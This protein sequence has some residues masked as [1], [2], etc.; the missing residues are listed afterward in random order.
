[1][2]KKKM[3]RREFL[4]LTALTGAGLAITACQPTSAP[5][6]AA[7][8]QVPPTA[9]PPAAAPTAIPAAAGPKL[10]GTFKIAQLGDFNSW[11]AWTMS[12][13]ND[14]MHNLAYSRLIW[15]DGNGEIHPDLAESWDMASDGLTLTMKLR[16]DVTWHDG[17]PFKAG[18]MVEMFG[19]T[20]DEA[21]KDVSG[22]QKIT[23]LLK[24][25]QGVTAPDDSTLVLTFPQPVPF[26][27]DILDYWY[28]ILI[29]DKTDG[30]LT[31]ELAIGTG[32]FKM[33]EW[34]PK[35]FTRHVKFP[36]YFQ[37]DVPYLDEVVV[38]RF[39]QQEI[40]IPNMQSGEV[41]GLDTIPH[42]EV[43]M[44]QTDPNFWV[45]MNEGS[46][47]ILNI[48]VNTQ[49]PPLDKKEVRQALSYAL[50][51]ETITKEV[52]YGINQPI[53]S[54]FYNPAS[55]A[56]RDDLVM[57]H[58]FD[59]D[60]A[61]DLLD[62]AGVGN[63]E[64]D[65]VAWAAEPTWK[66][67]A[68]IWQSDLAKIGV[69]LNI[70]EFETAKFY[71]IALKTSDLEGHNL[72]GWATGRCRR[73][74]AIFF[75]TQQQYAGGPKTGM[76]NPYGWY[77]PEYEEMV[78]GAR[79]ELDPALR[80]EMYQRANEILV[81]ELPMIQICTNLKVSGFAKAVQGVGTDLLGFRL[82]DKIWLDR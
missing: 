66:T 35:G 49:K 39:D 54:P 30:N 44:I 16:K 1:M 10:G 41:D 61:K 53:C 58:P 40:L 21:L 15:K 68:L 79:V 18:D 77:N 80:A 71:D 50:D 37:P 70:V 64:I 52:F 43:E 46:G 51:R 12:S 32:P 22:V 23:G 24:S 2:N 47:N 60:K 55:I 72:V 9:V 65:F 38:L 59:L 69:K 81:D 13:A 78:A 73:D 25:I 19:Y 4:Q 57:A 48:I 14:I 6:T 56:H 7:A 76:A 5:T 45:Q 11:N 26:I 27:Y 28:A 34:K 31:K 29:P 67:Y 75:Q 33:T 8:T 82:Y 17:K 36:D 63:I 20:T 62:K 74:P 42:T 3:S